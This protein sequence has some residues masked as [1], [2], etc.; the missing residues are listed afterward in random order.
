MPAVCALG[1][2]I[3][4]SPSGP[5]E[6]VLDYIKGDNE[7][8]TKGTLTLQKLARFQKPGFL[9]FF[10]PRPNPTPLLYPAS[11]HL[12]TR[13]VGEEQDPG[14]VLEEVL[15]GGGDRKPAARF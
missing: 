8:A 3:L 5:R 15:A 11:F 10:P 12:A 13:A 6:N 9:L 2:P 7:R 1:F 14:S 4:V